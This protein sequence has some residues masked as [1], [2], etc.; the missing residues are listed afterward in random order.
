M[1]AI[2]AVGASLLLLLA[3]SAQL[4]SADPI[5]EF[6][7]KCLIGEPPLYDPEQAIKT[8]HQVNLDESP[9]TRWNKIAAAYGP[10]MKAAVATVK[11]MLGMVLDGL[12]FDSL[13]HLMEGATENIREPYRTELHVSGGLLS[14]TCSKRNP[15]QL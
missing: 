3:C 13:V 7:G 15:G 9:E 2:G 10:Q 11:K 4:S 8:W 1:L 5:G 14:G 6:E 12:L